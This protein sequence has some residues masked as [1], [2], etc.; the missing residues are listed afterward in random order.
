MLQVISKTSEILLAKYSDIIALS[1][2]L[3]TQSGLINN[4][5]SVGDL[6][7]VAI[8]ARTTNGPK[9]VQLAYFNTEN[10]MSE[11][12]SVVEVEKPRCW[13]LTKTN[14]D[15]NSQEEIVLRVQGVICNASLPPVKRPFKIEPKQRRHIKQSLTLTGLGSTKFSAMISNIYDI[16][17][18]FE[19]SLPH[20]ALEEWVPSY[21]ENFE[22]LDMANQYFTD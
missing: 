8:D 2:T 19:R 9:V 16:R 17:H 15:D 7:E 14:V 18:V 21:Y 13:K 3:H 6:L 5:R 20:D 12:C 4:H 10:G 22:A 1:I 11:S